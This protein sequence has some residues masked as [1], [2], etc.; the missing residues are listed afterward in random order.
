MLSGFVALKAPV[1]VFRREKEIVEQLEG[2]KWI[3]QRRAGSWTEVPRFYLDR[4]VLR[5]R[6]FPNVYYDKLCKRRVLRKY[7]GRT[8]DN[9]QFARFLLGAPAVS[10][11]AGAGG[12]GGISW[13]E[14]ERERET[15]RV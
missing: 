12:S 4:A 13:R 2:G 3:E 10:V 1:M 7:E 9:R 15:L 5:T 8:G 6:S 11:E 14:R